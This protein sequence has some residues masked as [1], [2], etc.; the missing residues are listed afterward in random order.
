MCNL[1]LKVKVVWVVAIAN[2]AAMVS[3]IHLGRILLVSL[4]D[5]GSLCTRILHAL[6]DRCVKFT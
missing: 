5:L 2:T 6:V 1:L 3:A 4:F